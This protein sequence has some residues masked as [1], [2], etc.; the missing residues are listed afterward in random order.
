MF[1]AAAFA[2]M[3]P[4]AMFVNVTR[5]A[6]VDTDAL[7]AALR[8]RQ[9]EFAALDV[10]EPEPLPTDHPILQLDNVLLVPHIAGLTR[11]TRSQAHIITATDCVRVLQGYRPK[12][13]LNPAVEKVRPLLEFHG[14]EAR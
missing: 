8:D 9:I 3:Q 1:D 4:S 13:V 5:G 12:L 2:R 14:T 6:C 10:I 11:E 7:Y